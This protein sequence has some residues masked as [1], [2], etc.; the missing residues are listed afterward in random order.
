MKNNSEIIKRLL[1]FYPNPKTPL[2]HKNT[3][4]L[5]IAVILSAQTTDI[6][7]NKLT[8]EL[9]KKYPNPQSL[10]NAKV[11]DV[12]KLIKGVNYFRTKAKNIIKTSQI[13]LEQYN[14]EVP[15]SMDELIQ[16]AG[17]GRKTANV[18]LS[19]A[20]NKPIGVVVDTHVKRLSNRLGFT[21][22]QTPQK[23]ELELMKVFPKEYWRELSLA[24]IYHGRKRCFARKPDCKNCFLNDICP[25][26]FRIEQ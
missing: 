14:S 15:D 22:E 19:E 12:E 11:E 26:T 8:P 18:I 9:F 1:E 6:L 5:L 21:T 3:W 16:L 23:I 17:V 13:V 4:E 7:V 20:F 25:S 2:I 10:A 24:L